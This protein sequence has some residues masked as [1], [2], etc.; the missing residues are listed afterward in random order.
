MFLRYIQNI[1]VTGTGAAAQG[2]SES[3]NGAMSILT[4]RESSILL[5][6]SEVM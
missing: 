5:I 2:F 3:T 4:T 1:L 6:S